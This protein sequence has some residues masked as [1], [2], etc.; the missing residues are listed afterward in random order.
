MNCMRLRCDSEDGLP[1][2]GLRFCGTTSAMGRI[3]RAAAI[4][5]SRKHDKRPFRPPLLRI[6]CMRAKGRLAPTRSVLAFQ[7]TGGAVQLKLCCTPELLSRSDVTRGPEAA[8]ATGAQHLVKLLEHVVPAL[9]GALSHCTRVV[10]VAQV[11][12][13]DQVAHV[14]AHRH[15][16]DLHARGWLEGRLDDEVEG[17]PPGPVDLGI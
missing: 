9:L 14:H 2:H 12:R 15:D 3:L 17:Q 6:R 5:G 1:Y 16:V 8:P 13:E 7:P 10:A 4:N 11:V